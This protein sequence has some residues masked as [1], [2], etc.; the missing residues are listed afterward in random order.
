MN[1]EEKKEMAGRTFLCEMAGNSDIL[2]EMA[3][4]S[5]TPMLPLS[6]P[7][8]SFQLKRRATETIFLFE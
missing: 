6:S 5:N 3:G 2:C 8:T 4:N 1:S 7:N